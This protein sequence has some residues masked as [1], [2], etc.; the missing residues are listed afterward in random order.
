M[1]GQ[2]WQLD[3]D[4]RTLEGGATSFRLTPIECRLL[5]ALL[6][7]EGRICSRRELLDQAHA[8]AFHD[9]CDRTIDIH[10]RSL[11]HKIAA[12]SPQGDNIDSV[13]AQG[14]RLRHGS[15]H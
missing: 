4:T 2:A 9:V 13:Y 14:Y 11:R 12:V 8:G 15:G 7:A 6:A 10:I 5:C 3:A 1:D